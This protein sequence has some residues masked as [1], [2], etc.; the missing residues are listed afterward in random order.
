M[1]AHGRNLIFISAE[2]AARLKLS[3]G[4]K[5]KVRSDAGGMDGII[6]LAP[7]KSGTLQAYWPEATALFSRRTD[8]VSGERDCDTEVWIETT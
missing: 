3:D 5:V 7:V 8:P 4:A 1:G 2:D 6:Q